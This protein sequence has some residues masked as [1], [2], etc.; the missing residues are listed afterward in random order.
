MSYFTG[1]LPIVLHYGLAFLLIGGLLL[2]YVFIEA[3]SVNIPVIHPFVVKIKQF[4][5]AAALL[6]AA[7][8]LVYSTGVRDEGKRKDAQ[9]EAERKAAIRSATVTH[10]RAVSDVARGV[11]APRDTDCNKH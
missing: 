11:C 1:L 6:I 4:A 5:V 3:L 9:H 7:G 2:V 8:I 10:K